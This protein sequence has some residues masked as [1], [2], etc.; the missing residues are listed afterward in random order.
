[1][2]ASS[3]KL[4][5]YQPSERLMRGLLMAAGFGLLCFIVGL[6]INPTRAWGGFLMGFT[7]YTCM[8]LAGAVFVTVLVLSGSRWATALRRIPEAMSTGLPIGLLLG[9]VLMGGLHSLYEWTHTSVVEADPILSGKAAFLNV[10]GFF[11]RMVLYFFLWIGLSRALVSV[12]R[13]QDTDANPAE[14]SRKMKWRAVGFLPVF[15]ITFSLASVDWLQSLEPHWFSTIYALVTLSGLATSGLAVC[16]I[17]LVALRRTGHLRGIASRDHLDDLGKIAI[18]FALFW[19]YIWYCQYMLIWYTNMPEET[20]YY[21]IRSQGHWRLLTWINVALNW[22]IPFF[23]LMPKGARRNGTVM[24]RV[25]AVMLAG[26]ALQVYMLVA[27]PLMEGGPALG[28]WEI[29]PLMG[30]LALVFWVT[31]RALGQAPLVPCADP[32]L[33]AS[34]HHHC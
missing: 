25:A 16:I 5:P 20:P 8:C 10:P 2:S 12:S 13:R 18:G 19:G 26:Q 30:A 1:M 3:L 11:I 32:H 23:V 21:F 34:L 33:E 31:L 17:L 24:V 22:A 29:G 4:V 27:P 7:S 15:A 28:L 14:L 9:L 6:F